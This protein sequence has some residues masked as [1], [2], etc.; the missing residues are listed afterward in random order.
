VSRHLTRT[1][2]TIRA[3]VKPRPL[4]RHHNGSTHVSS[5]PLPAGFR[6][7]GAALRRVSRRS[8][9]AHA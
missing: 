1:R 6:D 2:A 9:G 3:Q 7:G 4:G 5:A 8:L